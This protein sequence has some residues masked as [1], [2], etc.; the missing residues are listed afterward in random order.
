MSIVFEEGRSWVMAADGGR[1]GR[2][3]FA[4]RGN[5]REVSALLRNIK[6]S[7]IVRF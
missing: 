1:R 5:K 7:Q 2:K 6:V 4:W 3:I